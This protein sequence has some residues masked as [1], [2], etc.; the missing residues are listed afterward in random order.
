MLWE[1]DGA[2]QVRATGLTHTPGPGYA[3]GRIPATTRPVR[4]ASF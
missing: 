4:M 1:V 2:I 3:I